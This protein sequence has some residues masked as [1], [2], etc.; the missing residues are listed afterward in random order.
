MRAPEPAALY[1]MHACITGAYDVQDVA[2]RSRVAITNRCPT[3]LNRG[4]GGPQLYGAL[5]RT[6][7]IAARRLLVRAGQ[8]PYRAAAGGIY[9]SGDYERCLDAVQELAGYAELRAAQAAARSEGRL[10]GIELA[11]VV[12]P[13]VSNMGYISLAQT[14]AERA[15]GLPE[16]GN[17]EGISIALGPHGGVTVRFTSTPQGQGH[18][19]RRRRARDRSGRRRCAHRR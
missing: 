16:S 4:F 11:C 12:E 9:D 18:R 6:M 14:P 1:R 10:V 5:E 2:V 8:M 3:G 13:S 19:T 15:A 7:A 17:S